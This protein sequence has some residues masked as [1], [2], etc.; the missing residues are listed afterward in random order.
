MASDDLRVASLVIRAARAAIA[1]LR[2]LGD[3]NAYRRHL[4]MTGRPHSAAEWR[5]FCDARLARKYEQAN[6]C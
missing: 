6:C 3:E 4:E 2:E 5:T 1:L